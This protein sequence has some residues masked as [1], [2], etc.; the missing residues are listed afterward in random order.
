MGTGPRSAASRDRQRRE[1]AANL[2]QANQDEPALL[3]AVS[4]DNMVQLE[5]SGL[6]APDPPVPG[7]ALAERGEVETRSAD[8]ETERV[9]LNEERVVP[10]PCDDDRWFL[11]TGVSN[12]MTGNRG[13]FVRLDETVKG[14]VKFGDGSLV[15][16]H[17]RGSVLIECKNAEH[18]VLT[19][20]YYIPRLRSN[21][22]SLGQLDEIGV[23]TVIEDGMLCLYDLQRRL[24]ARVRRMKNRLYSVTLSLA[25][26]VCLLAKGDDSVVLACTLWAF[27]FS[28]T[29]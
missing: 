12:H 16:I 11:D 15:D 24:L 6:R 23:K 8:V 28:S 25:A 27:A 7:T 5:G 10:V 29:A 14:T 21:I 13:M 22:I 19:E 17:G 3:L 4:G 2:A 18:R 20:V 1:E 9:F 26:P